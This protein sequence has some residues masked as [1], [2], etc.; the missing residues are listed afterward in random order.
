MARL[1]VLEFGVSCLYSVVR[2]VAA[3][4]TWG[5]ADSGDTWAVYCCSD[6]KQSVGRSNEE[7]VGSHFC[8]H[9][10]PFLPVKAALALIGYSHHLG[11]GLHFKTTRFRGEI[12]RIL[13]EHKTSVFA[14][15]DGISMLQF[16]Y[17]T[18]FALDNDS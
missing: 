12:W 16:M 11:E 14:Q 7:P 18:C 17:T 1:P 6:C 8:V 2:A 9:I 5:I 15:R 10:L 4:K 13:A 3:I